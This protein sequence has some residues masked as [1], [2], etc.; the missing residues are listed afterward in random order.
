MTISEAEERVRLMEAQLAVSDSPEEQMVLQKRIEYLQ[1]R[2]D[3]ARY[4]EKT[5]AL[6]AMARKRRDNAAARLEAI[7]DLSELAWSPLMDDD[8]V[9]IQTDETGFVMETR[10]GQQIPYTRNPHDWPFHIYAVLEHMAKL[11]I[12]TWSGTGKELKPIVADGPPL[13]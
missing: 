3:W 5:E 6:K 11:K 13:C 2:I 12:S 1:K 4:V 9:S 8:Q 10:N 7:W